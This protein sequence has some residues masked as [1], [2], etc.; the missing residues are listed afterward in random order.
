MMFF[1][2]FFKQKTAYEMR[3]SDWSSDVCSSDLSMARHLLRRCVRFKGR[4]WPLK[5]VQGDEEDDASSSQMA[6]PTAFARPPVTSPLNRPL[7]LQLAHQR[8]QPRVIFGEHRMA[9]GMIVE[10]DQLASV[11]AVERIGRVLGADPARK[12]VA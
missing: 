12:S 6:Q 2:F 10:A 3:I 5:Q 8:L 1:V 7:G 9:A 4:P 11:P